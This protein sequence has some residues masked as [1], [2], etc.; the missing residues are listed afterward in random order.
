VKRRAFIVALGGAAAWPLAGYAQ[1]PDRVRRI[2]ILMQWPENDPRSRA[3]IAV[4]GKALADFGWVEGR[5]SGRAAAARARYSLQDT[6]RSSGFK[7]TNKAAA[8]CISD[9]PS[10]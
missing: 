7:P 9:Q 4:L 2:G 5:A 3:S 1:Q 8:Y 6:K 10:P